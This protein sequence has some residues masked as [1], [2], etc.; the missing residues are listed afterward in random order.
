[1][2]PEKGQPETLPGPTMKK[3]RTK[4]DDFDELFKEDSPIIPN[5]TLTYPTMA[6]PVFFIELACH[7]SVLDEFD[8]H[9]QA[10]VH[11]PLTSVGN[12]SL[13]RQ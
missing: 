12:K 8:Q 11:F 4:E 2:F 5:P 3:I 9:F 13:L 6:Y 1:M 10:S 7:L